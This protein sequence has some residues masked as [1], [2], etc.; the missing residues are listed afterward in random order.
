MTQEK[1]ILT[2]AQLAKIV[3]EKLKHQKDTLSTA[4]SCTGGNIAHQ[5]TLISGASAYFKGSVVSYCN[6][7]KHSV[8]GVPFTV[9]E[10]RG[11]VSEETVINM[12]R[13]VIKLLNTDYALSISGLAGPNGDATDTEVGTVWICA[14]NKDG[15]YQTQ[16]HRI[17]LPREE[18][19]SQATNRALHLLLELL[20]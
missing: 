17:L 12:C 20:G 14:M 11:A 4:E 1:K 9:L 10:T 8:L 3:G 6:E 16:K 19:I 5:I 2:N 7:V 15:K 13:G 18:F